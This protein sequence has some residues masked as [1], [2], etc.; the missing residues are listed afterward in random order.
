MFKN[1]DEFEEFFSEDINLPCVLKDSD[2]SIE[3]YINMENKSLRKLQENI[4]KNSD[5]NQ[6]IKI[7]NDEYMKQIAYYSLIIHINEEKKSEVDKMSERMINEELKRVAILISGMIND[8]LTVYITES[9]NNNGIE[10]SN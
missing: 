9:E 3:I 10:E 8:N 1:S 6:S 5:D 2:E 7:L 4:T